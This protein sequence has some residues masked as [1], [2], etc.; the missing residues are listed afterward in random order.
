[1]SAPE[2][3]RVGADERLARFVVVRKWVRS[4]GTLKPDA[5][6]P[7]ADLQ[8]SVTRHARLSIKELWA[9]GRD[10]A[11]HRGKTLHGRADLSVVSV[12]TAGLDTVEWPLPENPEHAHVVGWPVDKPTQ[13]SKAQLLAAHAQFVPVDSSSS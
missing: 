10:V 11:A 5:F 8:L 4:E 9:R 2:G 12:R 3:L 13:K 7:P 6:M 1:M